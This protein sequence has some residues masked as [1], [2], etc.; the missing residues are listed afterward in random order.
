MRWF[1]VVALEDSERERSERERSE[2]RELELSSYTRQSS[3]IT[4]ANIYATLY[5]FC[6]RHCSHDPNEHGS[7]KAIKHHSDVKGG[8]GMSG[9]VTT[10][11][12]D[13]SVNGDDEKVRSHGSQ[14][15]RVFPS[16]FE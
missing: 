10:M 8:G 5:N 15:V 14:I 7:S 9:V 16:S 13:N 1:K 4:P 11:L 12:V 2:S 3:I 6:N